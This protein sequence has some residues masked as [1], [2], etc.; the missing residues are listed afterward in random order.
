MA[1]VTELNEKTEPDT[2]KPTGK[3]VSKRKFGS[4]RKL[5]KSSNKNK[6]NKKREF[7]RMDKFLIVATSIVAFGGMV[8][9]LVMLILMTSITY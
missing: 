4:A 7:S 3:A 9:C 8:F 6:K 2:G 1:E 5:L